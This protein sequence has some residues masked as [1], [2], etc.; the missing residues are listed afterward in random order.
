MGHT[1]PSTKESV[2]VKKENWW[3]VKK[4]SDTKG[5]EISLV[6]DD[7]NPSEITTKSGGAQ[8]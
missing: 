3:V 4:H 5:R 8:F 6:C 1:R 7:K 2:H